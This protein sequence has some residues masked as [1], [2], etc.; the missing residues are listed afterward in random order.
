MAKFSDIKK[1][2]RPA[3]YKVNMPWIYLE[4]WLERMSEKNT[5]MAS[6]E[7]NPDFQRGH[8][9]TDE[10]SIRYVEFKLSGGYAVNDLYFN[11][12][13]W[14]RSWKGPFVCVDGLQRITAVMKFL[15]N[16]IKA[17]DSF[18]KEYE[19]RL[20]L[21]PEFIIHVN[22]LETRKEVL[23]WYLE[24]NSNGR[25]HTPEELNKVRKLLEKEKG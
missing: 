19:D 20:G 3:Y 24:M 9:W 2:T 12:N 11:C 15:N 17:F 14:M 8:V 1:F 10:E 6:L 13:G 4:E 18:Y 21:E 5:A 23:Q 25:V 7:L 22:N 16:E